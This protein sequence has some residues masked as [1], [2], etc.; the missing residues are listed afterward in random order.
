MFP[1]TSDRSNS[2]KSCGPH[3]PSAAPCATASPPRSADTRAGDQGVGTAAA[4]GCRAAV[5]AGLCGASAE[6]VNSWSLMVRL[7]WAPL[8][9]PNHR[10][11]MGTV[12]KLH[13]AP[14]R[15]ILG[16]VGESTR[17]DDADIR[18]ALCGQATILVNMAAG[19]S[20]YQLL[21]LV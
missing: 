17:C 21:V 14:P 1:G 10:E 8:G 3:G 9:I 5:S 19:F 13:A 12:D 16:I 7:P 20:V 4:I 2:P 6:L 11:Q 18:R 15:E